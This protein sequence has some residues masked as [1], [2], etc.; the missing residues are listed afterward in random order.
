V[1]QQHRFNFAG[2]DPEAARLDE[3]DR[4][5]TDDAVHAVGVDDRDVAGAVPPIGVDRLC[6]GIRAIEVTVEHRRTPDMKL[7]NGFAV[8]RD[9]GTGVVDQSGLDAVHRQ[10]HPAGTTFPVGA[11]ADRDQRLRGAVPFDRQVPGQFG[12]PVEHGH[13]QRRAAGHQQ[14]RSPQRRCRGAVVDDS[15]PHGRDPEVQRTTGGR[16]EVGLRFSGVH[17][18]ISDAQRPEQPEYQTVHVIQGQTVHQGVLGRPLPGLGERVDVRADCTP[19]QHN[20]LGRAGGTRGVDDQRR[21]L[22]RRLGIA[23]P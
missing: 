4:L 8:I 3:V 16:I 12:Q 21:R 18:P 15:R 19:A 1:A 17:E 5:A 14:A 13:R 2:A 20:T 23:V 6:G 9:H 7:P 11:R 22:V 10:A